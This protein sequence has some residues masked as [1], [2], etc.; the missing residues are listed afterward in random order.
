MHL[1]TRDQVR[2]WFEASGVSIAEWSDARGYPRDTVYAV[3]SGRLRA[4]RGIAHAVA[5]D[6]R[7]KPPAPMNRSQLL[8]QGPK[9]VEEQ[10]MSP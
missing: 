4:R 8:Q 2:A 1:M 6:L 3:L 10:T 5:V 7:L 9:P